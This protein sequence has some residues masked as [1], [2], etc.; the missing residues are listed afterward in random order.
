MISTL[1]FNPISTHVIA[2]VAGAV[3]AYFVLKNNKKFLNASLASLAQ[4][5][6]DKAS[7][8]AAKKP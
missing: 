3:A 7:G 1:L 4:D 5:A 8:T 2:I 6:L